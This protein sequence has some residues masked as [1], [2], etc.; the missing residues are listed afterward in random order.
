MCIRLFGSTVRGEQ[1]C[2]SDIDVLFVSK[3][4]VCQE[5]RNAI[6]ATLIPRVKARVGIGGVE[7]VSISWYSEAHLTHMFK[8]G[9]LFAW[10]I[11]AESAKL[12]SDSED[13]VDRL[14]RPG[15]YTRAVE[16]ISKFR[17][18]L[19]EGQLAL[20]ASS[21]NADYEA[22][23]IYL[24][25]R[26][27]SMCASWFSSQ[28]LRFGRYSPYEIS[29]L[30]SFPISVET[31]DRFMQSRMFSARAGNPP[32]IAEEEVSASF[33]AVLQWC[34]GLLSIVER[35]EGNANGGS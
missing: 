2:L 30:S 13:L 18:I 23:M 11:F 15:S 9:H 32:T 3:Q 8:E 1:D 35:R 33:A 21:K 26:N 10:H 16:D 14:G 27:V 25:C 28:G 6:S 19:L 17:R 31:Y 22:G 24:C 34:D 4:S 29:D 12:F 5:D 20:A 7:S